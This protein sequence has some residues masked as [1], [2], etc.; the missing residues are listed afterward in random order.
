MEE[1]KNTKKDD[2]E[3]GAMDWVKAFIFAVI[4]SLLIKNYVFE[5]T[6]VSGSSMEE[7]LHDNDRLIVSKISL[8]FKELKR[9]DIVI[10][11]YDEDDDYVK[12]IVGMPGEVVQVID[13]GVYI[14][15]EL[16]EEDYINTDYTEN[17]VGFE[18]KL[19]ADEYF[20]MGDN[21]LPGKSK[22]SRDFGPVKV[23]RIIGKAV[24]RFYPFGQAF[25][26]LY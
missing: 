7:T 9:G 26:G 2:I 24:F 19:D 25:G 15:G 13:G 1:N 22:D 23:D 14:N 12:R 3:M 10:M 6:K 21:R 20:L 17:I 18:W 11:K 16:F 8:K 4:L 5:P